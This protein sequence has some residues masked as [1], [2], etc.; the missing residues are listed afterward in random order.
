MACDPV[1]Q[2]ND[3][4]ENRNIAGEGA[5]HVAIVSMAGR[6]PGS[7]TLEQ[8]WKNLR[9][10]VECINFLSD[11]DLHAMGVPR[12]TRRKKN[13]V[14]A[15][16]LLE[17]V[18]KFDA[19]FFGYPPREA[20]LMDPQHRVFLEC[21]W[22]ALEF[23]GYQPETYPGLIGVYAGTSLSSYLLYNVLPNLPDMHSENNFEVMIGNDKDFLSTRVAYKLNLKGPAIDV[24]TGCSTSLVA[25]HLACQALL[26]YQ[27]DMALAGGVSV[28]VPQRSGYYYVENGINSPDGHCRAFDAQAQGTI[29]GSGVGIVV[30]KRLSDALKD[31]DH[32]HAV[33]RASAIN[34]DGSQKV[35]YTA[36]SVE[37]QSSVILAAQTLAGVAPETISYV[38]CHGTATNLGDP[39]E[40]LALT[41]AFRGTG[42]LKKFC[43]LGAVKSN[44]GH[45]DAAAG[46]AGLIKTV[47]AMEHK[48][49]PPSLHFESPN[50]QI[51]FDNSPFYVNHSVK[52]WKNG[53]SPRRAGVSSFGIGGTNAHVILEEAPPAPV[54][55]LGRDFQLLLLSAKTPTALEAATGTLLD[56]L[57][58]HPES[59]L[60]DAA[61][62]LAVGRKAFDYRRAI[63]CSDVP[64]A[65]RTL[66]QSDPSRIFTYQYSGPSRAVVFM[67]PGGGAQYAQMG[68]ALYQTEPIFREQVDSC[69]KIL[70]PLLGFDIRTFLYPADSGL[71]DA[72]LRMKETLIGLPALFVTEY[73]LAKLWISWGILPQ[74]FIGHSLGE[75]TAAALAGVFSLQDALSLVVTRS[76]L[77]SQLPPGAMVGVPLSAKEIEPFLVDSL[78]LAAVNGES[79]CLVSGAQSAVDELIQ[80]LA[81]QEI[82]CR[83]LPIDVASH[84]HMVT[85]IMGAFGDFL[86]KL[87]MYPPRIPYISNVTGTWIT[88]EQAVNPDYWLLHL[89]Q[90]VLFGPGIQE[91]LSDTNRLFLEVGPGHTL[92]TLAKMSTGK[93]EPLSVLPSMRH[94]Y[95]RQPDVSFLLAA[96]GKL[97]L[98]GAFLDWQKFYADER[99]GRV[100]LPSYPFE[101]QRYWI[102]PSRRGEAG[103]PTLDKIDDLDQWFYL[104]SW[105]LLPL[106]F[107]HE[108]PPETDRQTWLIF[109][110]EEGLGR[111]LAET[112]LDSNADVCLV[113]QGDQ[114]QCMNDKKYVLNPE[115]RGDYLCLL[116]NLERMGKRRLNIIHLWNVT[117]DTSNVAR[118][119][120]DFQHLG[121]YSLVYLTQAVAEHDFSEPISLWVISTDLHKIEGKDTLIPDKSTILSPCTIIPQEYENISCWSIDVDLVPERLEKTGDQIL[122]E[123]RARTSNKIVAI[124]SRQRWVR[125]FEPAS[126]DEANVDRYLRPNGVYIITGGLGGIGLQ[127]AGFLAQMEGVR[128]AL[129]ERSLLPAQNQWENWLLEHPEDDL[130]SSKIIKIKE[131]RAKGLE[132]M[133]LSADAANSDQLR[134]A[135]EQIFTRWGKVD[136]LIHT[137]GVAG[138][139][140]MHL[141]PDVQ[142][143]ECERHFHAKVGGSKTIEKVLD[144]VQPEFCLLFSSNAALFGGLGSIAYSAASLFMDAFAESVASKHSTRWLSV[145]W[146]PWLIRSDERIHANY[147]T[148]LEKHALNAEESWEALR[149]VISSA[150]PGRI[151]VST[152]N[153]ALRM[154]L[155]TEG[156]PHAQSGAAENEIAETLHARPIL[157]TTY[158]PPRSEL[159]STVLGVWQQILGLERIG[160]HDNFFDLGGNSLFGL[161]MITAVKKSLQIDLPIMALFEG[162]TI[163]ALCQRIEQKQFVVPSFHE[164]QDRGERRR[165]SVVEQ[166]ELREMLH[167]A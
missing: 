147:Q 7:E 146:D 99:R 93:Q 152:G 92:S 34:N 87:E 111:C 67:F 103:N 49:L 65:I 75:Y 114:F 46:V 56:H 122:A 47:L 139:A 110:D 85:P 145:D 96:A 94:P 28:Q 44:I 86:R 136:G 133:V 128:L 15:A 167:P 140:A 16:P 1:N 5:L 88:E 35:G 124:R 158:V 166:S 118:S 115:S 150:S 131:L 40:V 97:W 29:F 112:L 148:G 165:N 14:K 142:K 141:I 72:S 89:R 59:A 127:I 66:Q 83:R 108:I 51:D 64:D 154:K 37:G 121:M 106:P 132:V 153:L 73:A 25:V 8:F 84:S 13:F 144:R 36:P 3:R 78:S 39:V 54:S 113:S 117:N 95:D 143:S 90:P 33:I 48:L 80:Q 160:V 38:E 23:A 31:G 134:T 10:G 41:N 126:M 17:N 58:T 164:S 26:C 100:V 50:P 149:R 77:F 155:W 11:E 105:K 107:T 6:F 18:D 62:T 159:E 101:R 137:A 125:S 138:D 119:F 57:Q 53:S 82:E 21:S 163:S 60:A 116:E 79:Q 69:A 129:I 45:L 157:A 156:R 2:D 130:V 9:D 20:E 104:P 81:E 22:E 43:A 4:P 120:E 162:P 98:A 109:L 32:I 76:K 151:V 74:A 135:M 68:L 42:D 19:A 24:Q 12:A 55:G 30:L 161:R 102:E 91:L 61:Y 71:K 123:I 63:I 27:C 52:E 70:Q